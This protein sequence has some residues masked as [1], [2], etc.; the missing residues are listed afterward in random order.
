MAILENSQCDVNVRNRKYPL[1]IDLSRK[2][3]YSTKRKMARFCK[4]YIT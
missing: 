2:K 1:L 3:R 4:T